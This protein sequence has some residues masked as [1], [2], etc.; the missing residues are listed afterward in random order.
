[1]KE[2]KEIKRDLVIDFMTG[3][4]VG[5]LPQI[6]FWLSVTNQE[7]LDF[8]KQTYIPCAKWIFV[9]IGAGVICGIFAKRW[10]VFPSSGIEFLFFCI[11]ASFS[12]ILLFGSLGWAPA[13]FFLFFVF[14]IFA[15][16]T[17]FLKKKF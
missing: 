4:F 13:A 3:V 6:F 11:G 15:A 5:L 16:V 1:M 9:F 7:R 2:W 17:V 14:H 10:H 8:Y 12:S